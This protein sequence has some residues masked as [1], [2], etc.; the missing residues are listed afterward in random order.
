MKE[1]KNL[2]RRLV[3]ALI[4]E[5]VVI[6]FLLDVAVAFFKQG[7]YYE[8]SFIKAMAICPGLIDNIGKD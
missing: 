6:V 4:F 8:K 1:S 3:I 5:A 2:I 7:Y